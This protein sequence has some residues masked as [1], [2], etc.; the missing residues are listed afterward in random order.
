MKYLFI[1]LFFLCGCSSSTNKTES[2][3]TRSQ[4]LL[5]PKFMALSM[6]ESAYKQEIKKAE[7]NKKK[8]LESRGFEPRSA[9]WKSRVLTTTPSGNLQDLAQNLR[10]IQS[11]SIFH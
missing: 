2:D 9:G 3:V 8:F 1:F 10:I 11:S 7:E 5:L 6:A 4:F